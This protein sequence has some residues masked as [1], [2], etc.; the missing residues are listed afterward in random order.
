MV[1]WANRIIGTGVE[2]PEQLLANPKNW[3]IHPLHQQEAL[4]SILDHI[5]WVQDVIVNKTTGYVVDGHLRV[6]MSISKGEPSVP[7][8]YVELTE[9]E[10]NLVLASLDPVAGLATVDYDAL[11]RLR[12]Q[13]TGAALSAAF[14]P[15]GGSAAPSSLG[16]RGAA[17]GFRG[18][19]DDNVFHVACPDCGHDFVVDVSAGDPA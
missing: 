8:S 11:E 19:Y 5:G 14:P 2:N 3:R 1:G 18:S 16:A 13:D 17:D 7:V 12:S 6:A 15:E 10:E 9:D 4:G